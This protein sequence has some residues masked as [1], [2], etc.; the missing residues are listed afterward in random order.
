MQNNIF[1]GLFVGQNLVTIKEVDSTNSFL[2]TLLSNSKP[3]PEGTVIM[4]ESQYAGRG[5]QQNKWHSEPGKNL[6][7]SILLTPTFLPVSQQF[8]LTRV[9]SL[10]VY[11]ALRPILGDELK[12]KWPNDI[13]FADRKLGGIL[14]ET[15]LQ[16]TRI[17]DAIIG[18]GLNINQ[19]HFEA[20]AGNAIS[21]K[22]I[23]HKDYDLRALLSEICGNIEA[24]YLQLKAGKHLLVRNTYL[25]RL[26]WLNQQRAFRSNGVVFNGTIINVKD[27][28]L[29]VVDNN[30]GLQ[31]FSLKQIEFLNK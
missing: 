31:E 3:V 15:H 29:L 25:T 26:Y 4:A 24:Y 13:Y 21:V 27:E 17:K 30:S 10:G 19:E 8:D 12:I 18:I 11:E 2:K 16:G 28:G 1:S 6:T 23:L 14:I 7:F 20:G 22:Q 9:I 5:Q